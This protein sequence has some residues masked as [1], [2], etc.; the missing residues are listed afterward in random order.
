M[1][2]YKI[3]DVFK[4]ILRYTSVLFL[5]IILLGLS[6]TE[7]PEFSD[8][9]IF[10]GEKPT[11]NEFSIISYNV[12][13]RP[14]IIS[15]N[16][17]TIERA[18]QIS[19]WLK[20]TGVD[21]ITLQETFE[22]GAVNLILEILKE[23]YPYYVRDMPRPKGL[24]FVSGG[25]LVLSKWPI[26]ESKSIIYKDCHGYDCLAAKG[27]LFVNIY[28]KEKQFFNIITTHLDAGSDEKDIKARKSQLNE[29][30]AFSNDV[31]KGS[32]IIFTG[33]FN[34]NSLS[35]SNEYQEMIEL[36]NVKDFSVGQKSTINCT[37]N[38][39]NCKDS[40]TNSRLDYIFIRN[41]SIVFDFKN[42]N[43]FALNTENIDDVN[44]LS[45]HILIFAKLEIKEND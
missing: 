35:L 33:D 10:L 16:E 34:V 1:R 40:L 25:L 4:K 44:F 23:E 27:A 11:E 36:L 42:L 32:E 21:V 15:R 5:S 43:Y 13:L 29:L 26:V 17:K 30:N 20:S 8:G 39:I 7:N 38:K 14:K 37:G 2:K 45:D 18:H 24:K 28:Y 31:S 6:I 3:K 41:K 22:G 9:P 19:N 12:F